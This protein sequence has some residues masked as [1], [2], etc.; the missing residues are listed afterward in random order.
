MNSHYDNIILPILQEVKAKFIVEIGA[1]SGENTK[2]L[3]DYCEDNNA[4]LIS[5]DPM[6]NFDFEYYKEAYGDKFEIERDF[7]LNILPKLENY[8]VILLDGDHNWYTVYNELKCIEKSFINKKFPV[9]FLHDTSWPYDRRDMYYNPKSIPVKYRHPYKKEGI[10][11]GFSE[12]MEGGVNPN[13][14]N[15]IYENTPRNG[16]LTAIEDFINDSEMELSLI[17]V[18]SYHGLGIIYKCSENNGNVFNKIINDSKQVERLEI[19]RIILQDNNRKLSEELDK[20][21]KI[22]E[23]MKKSN[24]W[25][26][27]RPF[28][29]LTYFISRKR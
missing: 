14:N 23:C 5:V 26:I 7:S 18:P 19:A 29:K 16:V 11:P 13:T 21:K 22:I 1:A 24:S 9:I 10:H 27:T 17:N 15:A 6:P 25:K 2:N 20:S 12:P 28:R 4:K 3:L 8:D